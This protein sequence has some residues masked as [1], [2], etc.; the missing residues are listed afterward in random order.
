[1]DGWTYVSSH[2]HQYLEIRPEIFDTEVNQSINTDR[3][4]Q[5]RPDITK[6]MDKK[7]STNYIN[8]KGTYINIHNSFIFEGKKPKK[9]VLI[10]FRF[11]IQS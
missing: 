5:L 11:A 4:S 6:N 2:Y 9:D 8:A 3:R 7:S 10:Q 1:M